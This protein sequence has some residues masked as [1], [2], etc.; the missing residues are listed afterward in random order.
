MPRT[1]EPDPAVREIKELVDPAL[2]RLGADVRRLGK[3]LRR[4]HGASQTAAPPAAVRATVAARRHVLALRAQLEVLQT[5]HP[6][7]DALIEGLTFYA[8][9]L[10]ASRQSLAT[11]DPKHG[12]GFHRL[13]R[14]R[15]TRAGKALRAADRALGCVYGC[16]EA[17]LPKPRRRAR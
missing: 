12:T 10:G 16:R 4:A 2:D 3:A 1:I 6:A 9:A 8:D 7:K 5:D 15:F 13:A 11:T 17:K 14:D